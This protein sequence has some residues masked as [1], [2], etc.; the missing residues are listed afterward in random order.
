MARQFGRDVVMRSAVVLLGASA[1]AQTTTRVS[2]GP[3]GAQGNGQCFDPAVSGNGGLVAYYSLASTL[4]PGDTNN[5]RDCFLSTYPGGLTERVSI[6]NTEAQA[7]GAS[8]EESFIST[9]PPALSRNGR[10]VAFSSA[11]TN[12]AG[13]DNNGFTDIYLRDRQQ[14]TTVRVSLGGGG[15]QPNGDCYTFRNAISDDGRYVA[16][17]SEASNLVAGDTNATRDVFVRD[18]VA[19]TTERVSV[20]T[21]G[22]QGNAISWRAMLSADGR[23]VLFQSAAATLIPFD[24]NGFTDVF[25]RDRQAG[26]TE[27]VSGPQGMA[28]AWG[29]LSASMSPDA[30]YVTFYSH[31]TITAS[32]TNNTQD[33][34]LLDRST[35][36]F[37][38][39]S[40]TSTGGSGMGG[41]FASV[42]G[43]A[44][45]SDG[46]LVAFRS[47]YTNLVPGD[48][49]NAWDVFVRDRS[50]GTLTRVSVSSSEAQGNGSSWDPV[51]PSDAYLVAFASEASTLVAGDTNANG[52]VFVRTLSVPPAND[53]C[54]SAQPIS[55]PGSFPVTNVNATTG[56]EGQV[57]AGCGPGM[58]RDVWYAWT[59][60]FT[61]PAVVSTC[62][63]SSDTK[64]AVYA[65]AGCPAS[66]AIA[67]ADDG[68]GQAN[69][70]SLLS[71]QATAGAVY[72]IQVAHKTGGTFTG[73]MQ[74]LHPP[75]QDDC[76]TPQAISGPGVFPF[77]T[78]QATTGTAG[79]SDSGCGPEI[80]RDVWF[81]W[82]ATFSGTAQL[83]SCGSTTTNSKLAVYAGS[84]CPGGA[85]LACNDD[86]CSEQSSLC[87]PTT[88][89]AVYL[90]QVGN[91]PGYP[92]GSGT[93]AIV[94][95]S[96]V[97]G[98]CT[99][100][101]DGTAET[102][103]GYFDTSTASGGSSGWLQRFGEIGQAT[104]VTAVSTAWSSPVAQ[105]AQL[106]PNGSP[107]QVAIWDDPN[108]DGNP[109][110]AVLLQLVP[111]SLAGSG[112]N[113][114]QSFA[115]NPPVTVSGYFFVGAGL[116]H[117]YDQYPIPHD[118]PGTCSG[119]DR[120]WTFGCYG[121][122]CALNFANL[123]ANQYPPFNQS[124]WYYGASQLLVRPTCGGAT[125]FCVPATG[126]V[127]ACPCSN[128]GQPGKG[129]DNSDATGGALLAAS[130]NATVAA[131]TLVFT[132][133]GQKATGVSIVLQGS[134]ASASG[135]VFGQG[136]RCTAGSLKRL[137]TKVASGG[138]ITAPQ[139]G[140]PSVSAQS[141]ALGDT[142]A[143]GGTR[144]YQVYYRDPTVLGGCPP[145]STFNI[146]QGL[147][148]TWS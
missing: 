4:V 21:A 133:S 70:P 129:C 40:S 76:A 143:P 94:Q 114:L 29:G 130:G 67:C 87:F 47:E 96:V 72:A 100:I 140:D 147:V 48:T 108:D 19:G 82:T 132:T 77:D 98:A 25:L 46:R 54:A 141:A 57:D 88:A 145:G 79:Q 59:S 60:T 18:L 8:G 75:A 73:T 124:N 134:A 15:V 55:G 148:V 26:T 139:P 91:S 122:G 39:V 36:V 116:S 81:A 99:P 144:W 33:V 34:Y 109:I 3:A 17:A 128:P 119:F 62:Q 83:S 102:A 27:L 63:T 142:I 1:W 24:F 86:A 43:P 58:Q 56:A 137:Y 20:S 89:G 105:P 68:C 12:L 90:L 2:L 49:N 135:A 10:W 30:R 110:D 127:L 84:G 104:S 131:D 7:N 41:G 13:L 38:L 23:Y 14:G 101:D 92:S 52:D 106:P 103:S 32:D 136:I 74:I 112:T 61:G 31:D 97:A 11:A 9:V 5:A 121:T 42:A 35:G 6:S 51:I 71:F 65:G 115:L 125:S 111:G 50:T 66:A 117:G 93:F 45:S 22:A 64:L 85:A 113:A 107:V 138:S 120:A 69:G 118:Q 53:P 78:S 28:P 126:G 37:E 146:T 16:F 95:S 80:A 123:G 44:V